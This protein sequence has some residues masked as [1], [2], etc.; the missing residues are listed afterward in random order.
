VERSLRNCAEAQAGLAFQDTS[1]GSQWAS[2]CAGRPC[3]AGNL[4]Y[5]LPTTISY[6]LK[7]GGKN[8]LI[9]LRKPKGLG[10]AQACY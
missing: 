4:L 8:P 9:L 5:S 3:L 7:G 2:P 1:P 10:A 6:T